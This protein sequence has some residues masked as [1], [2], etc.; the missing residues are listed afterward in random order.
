MRQAARQFL[1]AGLALGLLACGGPSDESE[2]AQNGTA[3]P[4]TVEPAEPVAVEQEDVLSSLDD[5]PP[6]FE[7]L[8]RP[9]TGDLDGMA[10][11]RLVRLLTT[12]E[13][14]FYHLDGAS[15]SGIVYESARLF[16]KALNK[17]LERNRMKVLVVVVPLRR[18]Q[19]VPALVEGRGDIIAANLTI[20]TERLEQ[21]DFSTPMMRDVSEIVVSGTKAPRLETLQDLSGRE[22]RL[23]RSSSYW[24]SVERLNAAFVEM[25]LAPVR[26]SAAPPDLD[27]HDLLKMVQA[28]SL[29][30]TVVDSHKAQFWARVLDKIVLHPELALREGG[31]IAWAFRQN[32]PK[33]REVVDPFVREHRKGTLLG[34]VL[35][36]RY[37]E[38]TSWNDN[39]L[40][41]TGRRRLDET[42]ALFR[43]YGEQYGFDWRLLAAQGYQESGL[44]QRKRSRV[45]ALGVMQILPDAAKQ[46]GITDVDQ[47]ENNIHAG[48]KYMRHIVDHYLDQPEID[49]NQQ[50]LLALASYNAGPTRIRNLRREAA[51][52]GLDP[53]VW[54]DNVE[55]VVA[56]RVGSETV[57]YVGNIVRYHF[58]YQFLKRT[59]EDGAGDEVASLSR[60]KAG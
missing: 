41:P 12:Y 35:Y 17:H 33:L 50:H 47:L 27:D 45:G 16:E 22:L 43:K 57:R 21:V 2:T 6:E 1:T 49:P 7:G 48:V 53:N 44:D 37:L 10:E 39:S 15:Q 54:F 19:L 25:D 5:M 59:D 28:G 52:K 40:S 24:S 30:M 29:E 51:S 3:E 46:V 20:T 8:F 32:S 9:W 11:R 34:N 13:P 55:V 56:R 4:A 14:M 38:N 58:A 31:E 18:D 42:V 36:Q 23:R 26:L 60:S